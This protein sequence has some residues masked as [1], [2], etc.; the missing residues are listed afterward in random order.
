MIKKWITLG[1]A[2]SLAVHL[3]LFIIPDKTLG[4]A[5][6]KAAQ[7][8]LPMEIAVL[9]EKYIKQADTQQACPDSSAEERQKKTE[10]K[11][12]L[13]AKAETRDKALTLKRHMPAE[14]KDMARSA[15]RNK[16]LERLSQGA[17]KPNRPGSPRMDEVIKPKPAQSQAAGK[18]PGDAYAG[19][20]KGEN[21]YMP[22]LKIDISDREAVCSAAKY[23]GMRFVVIDGR[24]NILSEVKV[25][26]PAQLVPFSGSLS[27]FSNRVRQLPDDYL[28]EEISSF[29]ADKGAGLYMLVPVGLD[30]KFMDLQ[31]KAVIGKGLM[32]DRVRATAGKFVMDG[33]AFE[34]M[35]TDVIER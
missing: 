25:N 15:G 29:L 33:G 23:F 20:E 2:V 24:N 3:A 35:I 17:E 9:P 32:P 14:R 5:E 13:P 28:G 34:L 12:E 4:K 27:S 11:E 19:G 16:A 31:K 22:E 30:L 7:K 21:D 26:S 10:A 1:L 18:A 6:N 8:T